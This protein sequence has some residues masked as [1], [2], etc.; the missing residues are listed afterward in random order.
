MAR[1]PIP[2][3][4]FEQLVLLAI[5]AHGE[6][7]YAV[8]IRQELKRFASRRTSRGALYVTLERLEQKGYLTSRLGDPVDER[9]GRP[10]RFYHVTPR[11]LTALR[12]SRQALVSL[13][14][15]AAGHR[16]RSPGAFT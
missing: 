4:E 14:T 15:A 11:A 8:P 3:G 2:L 13:W 9:G 10:R 16:Q 12:R 6:D 1:T 5:L 7:A